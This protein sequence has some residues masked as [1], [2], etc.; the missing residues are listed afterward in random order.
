MYK[1]TCLMVAVLF[2]ASTLLAAD[3]QPI[4]LPAPQLEGGKTLMQALSQ[5]KS[6]RSFSA[7]ELPD[8]VLSSL[9]WAACG[10]NR[11]DSGKRTAP[12]G[13]N[14]QEIEIYAA[15]SKGLYRY[16]AQ[17]HSLVP[18]LETDI[19]PLT[20]K[21][22]FVGEAPVNLIYVADYAKMGGANAEERV[23]YSAADTG[24]ISQ[25]VYLFCASEGLATVVRGLLDREALAGA[26]K[27]RDGQ[28][29][30]LAQTVG[31]PPEVKADNGSGV[32][33]IN[34][35]TYDQ[36][37]S[38]HLM[39]EALAKKII[40]Y[41]YNHGPFDNMNDLFEVKGITWEFIDKLKPYIVFYGDTTYES[42]PLQKTGGE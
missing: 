35:V 19:R 24:F 9:L 27:L 15:T 37:V 10:V 22:P 7:K 28:K 38:F 39:D 20:G 32:I 41:R 12:S 36:L 8:K 14:W 6:A 17:G 30:I 42:A 1:R 4:K 21:Q 26:M 31:Y 18:V 34:K 33:N 5:R 25:N 2:S 23:F 16:Q 3:V 40:D 11:S 29:I 13:M